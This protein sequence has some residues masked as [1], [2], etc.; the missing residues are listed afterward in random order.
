MALSS[1]RADVSQYAGIHS[2]SDE[3]AFDKARVQ[4]GEGMA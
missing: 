1:R 3:G 4:V 2:V